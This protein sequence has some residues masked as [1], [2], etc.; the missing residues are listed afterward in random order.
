MRR[1]AHITFWIAF[2]AVGIL[3]VTYLVL[4]FLG[5]VVVADREGQAVSA[6]I[7]AGDGTTQPMHRIPGRM[8]IAIPRIEGEIAIRCRNGSVAHGGYVTP[9][10]DGRLR[11]AGACRLVGR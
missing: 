6:T 3:L 2:G 11:V 9:H 10:M 7:V 4:R 1:R 8:F 5:S